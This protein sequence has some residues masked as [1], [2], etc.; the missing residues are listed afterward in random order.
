[1]SVALLTRPGLFALRSTL[2][3]QRLVGSQGDTA[4]L[5]EGVKER[6]AQAATAVLRALLKS[7]SS[8]LRPASARLSTLVAAAVRRKGFHYPSSTHL[9]QRATSAI[10]RPAPRAVAVLWSVLKPPGSVL[11]L[12]R[13]L[14]NLEAAAA[15]RSLAW[16]IRTAPLQIVKPTIPKPAPRAVA[17]SRMSTRLRMPGNPR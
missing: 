6:H 9:L 15:L 7:L 16:S 2:A 12:A 4:A 5:V 17:A 8:V 14:P 1:M 13:K 11:R 10:P 3:A